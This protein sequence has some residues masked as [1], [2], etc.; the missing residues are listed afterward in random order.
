MPNIIIPFLPKLRLIE[1]LQTQCQ[2]EANSSHGPFVNTLDLDLS[3]IDQY[4][5][6]E[7]IVVTDVKITAEIVVVSY[8]VH[9]RVFNGCKGM[10]RKGYLDKKATGIRMP[11]GWKFPRFV[12]TEG[13][14]TMDEF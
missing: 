3:H 13:R 9:Y 10:D 1:Y 8:D 5:S 4:A 12:M 7:A 6:V 14:S 11:N 2:V